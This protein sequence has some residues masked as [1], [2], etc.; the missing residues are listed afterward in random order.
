MLGDAVFP[1]KEIVTFGPFRL[2][3]AERLLEKNGSKVPLGS[4]ALGLLLELVERAGEVVSNAELL[5]SVWP[6]IVVEEG[7]LRVHLASLRKALGDGQDGAKYVTNVPGRGYCFVAPLTRSSE[8]TGPPRLAHAAP[9]LARSETLPARLLRMIGREDAVRATKAQLLAC[10]FVTIVGPGGIGKTTVAVAVAHELLAAFENSVYFVDLSPLAEP[11]S[12]AGTIASVLGLSFQS[13]NP[14]GNILGFLR[15]RE[16]LL[17]LDCCEHLVEATAILAEQLFK[18]APLVHILATSRESLRVEGEHVQRLFPLENPPSGVL[19][20]AAEI[21]KYP[22]VQ[23]FV[24]RASERLYQFELTDKNAPVV[25]EI[26]RRLDGIALAIEL[27]AGRVDAYGVAGTAGLLGDRFRLLSQGRRTAMPRHQ[28][29]GAALDWSHD[30]LSQPER[31]VFRRLSVFAGTF[32]LDAAQAV[33]AAGAIEATTALDSMA[34]LVAKSLASA[35]IRGT[36]TRYRLLDSTRAYALR[37]L[38][39]SGEVQSCVR[40]HATYYCHFLQ[41]TEAAA[42]AGFTADDLAAHALD[43]GNI[44]TGLEWAFSP[45]GDTTIAIALAS[46]A[47]TFFVEMSLLAE[48]RA[49]AERAI[50]LLGPDSRGTRHEMLLQMSLGMSILYATSNSDKAQLALTRAL[51]LAEELDEP[52]YQLHVLEALCIFH[53]QVVAVRQKLAERAEAVIRVLAERTGKKHTN[54][55]TG[56][57]QQFAG[58]QVGAHQSAREAVRNAPL[59]RRVRRFGVDR[60]SN[61]MITLARALWMLGYPEQAV[62]AAGRVVTEARGLNHAVSLCTALHWM[63]WVALWSGNL[64]M[65]NDLIGELLD[66]SEKYSLLSFYALAVGCNGALSLRRGDTED[67]VRLLRRSLESLAALQNQL[68]TTAFLSELAEALAASGS[69]AASLV[70]IDEVIARIDQTGEFMYLPEALRKK[71]DILACG[72]TADQAIAEEFL[73]RSLA[74]TREQGT[75]SWELRTAASIAQLRLRQGLPHE[76][77]AA[78]APVY[79]RFREGFDTTD[80][81]VAK[82]LLDA[83][84]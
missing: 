64:E 70:T 71:A 81:Q 62:A 27:A 10:R 73:W 83:I 63:T 28:T 12:V 76:A 18:E 66:C 55:M 1:S 2:L 35:D 4:R 25:A 30:L 49:W 60:R 44:R 26:C 69:R 7:S 80:L 77:R 41:R 78:L 9:A 42:A 19:L 31:M 3:P 6:D 82:R 57:W 20:T 40:R 23:L 24:E 47:S 32:T 46:A 8:P 33:V 65:A 37:K 52:Y 54:W 17:V 75:L 51:Q 16:T 67:A 36:S 45:D 79:G 58:N 53:Q 84:S 34:N 29:L 39:D 48:C 56:S 14:V 13:T 74:Y 5:H 11:A 50:T 22:A 68:M 61:A 38:S 15:T 43:A 21:A 72:T 59:G